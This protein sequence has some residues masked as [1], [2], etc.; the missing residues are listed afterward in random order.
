MDEYTRYNQYVDVV[1]CWESL[2]K[3]EFSSNKDF[4]FDRFPKYY[5]TKNANRFKPDFSV[6]INQNYGILFEIKRTVGG[7]EEGFEDTID[8]LE[9]YLEEISQ[10]EQIFQKIRMW[11]FL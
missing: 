1:S 11:F 2:L 3:A 5:H 7:D 6:R 10:M 4:K 9:R 8:Q